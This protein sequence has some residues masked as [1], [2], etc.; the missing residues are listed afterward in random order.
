MPARN[1][2]SKRGP[3][4]AVKRA[5]ALAKL[6]TIM[7]RRLSAP[8][9]KFPQ[10]ILDGA[11]ALYH[12]LADDLTGGGRPKAVLFLTCWFDRIGADARRGRKDAGELH[13]LFAAE[14]TARLK[15]LPAAEEAGLV[16]APRR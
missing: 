14:L 8:R 2:C 10:F 9:P 1:G 3:S 4:P 5:R 12:G 16:E 15:L 7:R 13:A 11:I 6:N